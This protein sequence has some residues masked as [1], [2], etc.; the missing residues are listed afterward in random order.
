MTR[1][2]RDALSLLLPSRV[3]CIAPLSIGL[4][5]LMV[6][7]FLAWRATRVSRFA[8]SA[9]L[10]DVVGGD[11][12]L[13]RVFPQL[14]SK[15]VRRTISLVYFAILIFC[16]F[17]MIIFSIVLNFLWR[18]GRLSNQLVE[19]ATYGLVSGIWLWFAAIVDVSITV[20]LVCVLRRRIAGFNA[21]LDGR[22]RALCRLAVLSASYTAVLALYAAIVTYCTS[23][24]LSTSLCAFAR[25]NP[26][27]R[28]LRQT[29]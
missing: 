3:D 2:A 27:P 4:N 23:V 24:P 17:A 29:P 13:T 20:I 9:C 6:Q 1:Q 15:P 22:L 16:E 8:L 26:S 12:L 14:M 11:G 19:I 5:G 10:G 7:S 25:A 28:Q 21:A 18:E